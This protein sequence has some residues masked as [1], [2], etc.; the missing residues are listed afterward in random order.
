MS[1]KFE[2]KIAIIISWPRE[3]D[4]YSNFLKA[5]NENKIFDFVVNDITSIEKGRNKSN[6]LIQKLLENKK[7]KF[8]LLTD[9]YKKIKY[10]AVISTGEISAYRI[11]LY[12]VMRFIYANSVGIFLHITK[13][14]KLLK[15]FFGRPFTAGAPNSIKIG[16]DWFPEKEIG[17]ISIKFPDG[18]DLK[19]RNYPDKMYEPAFDIFLSYSDLDL[20]LVK[21]KFNN[22]V[23]KK[24]LYFRHE[25]SNKE[26]NKKNLIKEFNLDPQKKI[27][28]WLP[29]HMNIKDEEDRNILDWTSKVYFL[30]EFYNFIVRPH[31]KS[32]SRNNST[33]KN[34][35]KYNFIIDN[36]YDRNI[37]KLIQ[38]ADI[39]IADYGAIIFEGLYMN[40]NLVLLNMFN[41]SKYVEELM[42]NDAVEIRIRK[43]LIFLHQNLNNSEIH[44]KIKQSLSSDY[45]NTI[46]K[47]KVEIFGDDNN[48]GLD[49][50][51]F[52]NFLKKL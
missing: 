21:Q 40:K 27:I 38:C 39:I 43:E 12:S 30:K 52:T 22:K 3:I 10:K 17:N 41:G 33:L 25:N 48:K 26:D 42:S 32:I 20:N 45:Q 46:K 31:P 50:I 37:N 8:K 14:S 18:A 15:F 44:S 1:Q 36:D 49:Y 9:V 6:K 34:L 23:C 2:D 19:L 28:I 47:K 13:I 35:E 24:I 5:S 11:N 7:I 16:V 4:L 29:T 51:E